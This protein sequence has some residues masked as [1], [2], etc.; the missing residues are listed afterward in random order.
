[1]FLFPCCGPFSGGLKLFLTLVTLIM[2]LVDLKPPSA[3][4]VKIVLDSVQTQ[5][6][7]ANK[8]CSTNN[9]L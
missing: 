7:C 3:N 1:M 6:L 4:K 9:F 2:N 8:V 5:H